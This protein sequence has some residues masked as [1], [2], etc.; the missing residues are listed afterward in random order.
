MVVSAAVLH[1]DEVG[2]DRVHEGL[3][4]VIGAH[5]HAAEG[6]SEQAAGRDD[7]IVLVEHRRRIIEMLV[8]MDTLT[9]EERV[10]LCLHITVPRTDR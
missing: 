10:H 4:L 1:L 9:L 6:V 5:R 2:N 7:M 8:A 3:A